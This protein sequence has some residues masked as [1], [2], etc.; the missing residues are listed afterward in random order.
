MMKIMIILTIIIIIMRMIII[1]VMAIISVKKKAIHS[2]Y[3]GILRNC[4]RRCCLLCCLFLLSLLIVSIFSLFFVDSWI[5]SLTN[6]LLH[7]LFSTNIKDYFKDTSVSEI[8]SFVYVK[9]KQLLARKPKK[10]KLKSRKDS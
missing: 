5:L 1:I 6:F 4:C 10:K 9:K 2:N 7:T 3:L 8:E